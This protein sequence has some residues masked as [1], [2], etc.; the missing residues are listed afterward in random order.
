[1]IYVNIL[2]SKIHLKDFNVLKMYKHQVCM[3]T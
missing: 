2:V 3:Y 1:M